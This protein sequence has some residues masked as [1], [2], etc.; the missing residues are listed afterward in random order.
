MPLRVSPPTASRYFRFM[1]RALR[2][3]IAGGIYHVTNRGNRKQ[4]IFLSDAD[5]L[6][7]LEIGRKIAGLR[8]WSV[9]GYC[10][11]QNHYH[12]VVETPNPDL[13]AGMQAINSEY[14][15]W[16]NR[17]HGFV[18]HVFQGRFKA[19]LIESDWH[20]LELA[21]YL[22]MNP[23]RAGLCLSPSQWP[24]SSFGELMEEPALPLVHSS[25][26]LRF[27]GEDPERARQVFRKFVEGH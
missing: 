15:Q 23:V 25:K 27:F 24:W 7:F 18:G 20:L 11:M 16:F 26:V 1:P 19:V 4:P 3:L 9:H 22:A 10:L 5:R 12:L 21:R 6:L 13:S 2:R 14:A 8:R 17:G